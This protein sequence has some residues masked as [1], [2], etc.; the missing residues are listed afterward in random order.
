NLPEGRDQF[1]SLQ[2][3]LIERFAELREQHGFNYLH[4]ACCRDT[5]EDRGTVQYLQDCAAEAEVATEFLY[6]EDIGL[7][8]RGQFT[9]T[10]DQVISNLFKLYPWE[11]MLREV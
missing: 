5:V 9:D 4:L 7:G 6:I 3:K 10:Q 11:Y 1:N 8:E 2:E